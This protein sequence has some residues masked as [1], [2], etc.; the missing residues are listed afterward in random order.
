P[1]SV[2]SP[3]PTA[4]YEI[5][6]G[7]VGSEC[8]SETAAALGAAALAIATGPTKRRPAAPGSAG[9]AIAT[10]GNLDFPAA[11]IGKDLAGTADDR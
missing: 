10:S 4:A 6:S 7:R 1:S 11:C 3:K 8:V 9:F 5:L 2:V